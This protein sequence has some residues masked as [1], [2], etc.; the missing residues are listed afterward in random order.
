MTNYVKKIIRDWVE[1]EV[2][3]WWASDIEAWSIT[4]DKLSDEVQSSLAKADSAL[5]SWKVSKSDLSTDVQKDLEKAESAIS[6]NLILYSPIL[7]LD[8]D[9]NQY[10]SPST[11]ETWYY[12]TY[13]YTFT[14]DYDRV[15]FDLTFTWWADSV[16]QNYSCSV[17]M[18]IAWTSYISQKIDRWWINTTFKR[19]LS[20]RSWNII[21]IKLWWRTRWWAWWC[22]QKVTW[23]IDEYNKYRV[24][25]EEYV[26]DEKNI[27]WALLIDS[28]H[29]VPVY[30]I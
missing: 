15:D 18:T 27:I 7:H 4:L 10:T 17:D 24:R 1:Y 5:Q 6:W 23:T 3:W 25:W 28:T 22:N 14:K 19:S 20:I 2:V 9:K 11:S 16:Y 12:T 13:T 21:E 29:K 8:V 26:T 30:K